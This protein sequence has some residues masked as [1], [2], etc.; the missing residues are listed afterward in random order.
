MTTP[1]IVNIASVTDTQA[2]LAATTAM[3]NVVT[4]LSSSNTVVRLNTILVTNY[5]NA[6]VYANVVINRSATN[7]YVSGNISIP[8]YSSFVA[9]SKDTALYLNEGDYLQANVSANTAATV[10]T[11]YE[12]VS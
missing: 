5:S 9:S 3:T 1:N 12:T 11:A 7:Y 6:T 2:V 4:N 8:A 10:L